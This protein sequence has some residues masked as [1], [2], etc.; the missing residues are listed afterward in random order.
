MYLIWSD[1]FSFTVGKDAL[2]FYLKVYPYTIFFMSFCILLPA[3][4]ACV[5]SFAQL[6]AK[7]GAVNIWRER[8]NEAHLHWR[9]PQCGSSVFGAGWWVGCHV[10]ERQHPLRYAHPS[11]G[12]GASFPLLQRKNAIRGKNGEAP[13]CHTAPL[14]SVATG[15]AEYSNLRKWKCLGF[16]TIVT[17]RSLSKA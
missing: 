2:N 9:K 5:Q 1:T 15:G 12:L 14:C 3:S 8:Q 13:C 16:S 7:C 17:A 4:C 6:P 11:W 10:C